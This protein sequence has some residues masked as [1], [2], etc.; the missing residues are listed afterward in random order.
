MVVYIDI[1][2][3]ENVI[4]NMILFK[5]V[6]VLGSEKGGLIR[7]II[8][9]TIG[10]LFSII[11]FIYRPMVFTLWIIKILISLFMICIAYDVKNWKE[12]K[13]K[14]VAFYLVSFVFAGVAYSIMEA[15]WD[16]DK[17]GFI[18]KKT[19]L[20]I[21]LIMAMIF[22]MV[23]IKLA[24]KYYKS[25]MSKEDMLFDVLIHLGNEE[26]KITA[27]LDTGNLLEERKTGIP[28]IVAE[29]RCCKEIENLLCDFPDRIR[30]IPFR[31]VGN[32]EDVLMGIKVDQV[33]VH[34]IVNGEVKKIDGAIIG[35]YNGIISMNK[36]YQALIGL[37]VL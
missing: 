12:L 30:W 6:D 11:F 8:A 4:I 24:F 10:G 5:S 31:S 35:L 18:F 36:K 20:E 37:N 19:N 22:G 28:V 25:K 21:S 13:K 2:F 27:M 33:H 3:F 34:G 32:K 14:C 16:F 9:S 26:L 23:I 29:S 15:V 7:K 17:G 1:I